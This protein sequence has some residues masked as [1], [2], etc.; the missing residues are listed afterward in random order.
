MCTVQCHEL[1]V[2]TT[3]VTFILQHVLFRAFRALHR[4]FN[5]TSKC[6]IK[7]YPLEYNVLYLN[8]QITFT[9]YKTKILV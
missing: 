8:E 7:L 6:E 4:F 2:S 5:A 9:A 1:V 3:D